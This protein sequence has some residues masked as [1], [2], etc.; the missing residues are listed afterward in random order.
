MKVANT[1][2]C[3]FISIFKEGDLKGCRLY[4]RLDYNRLEMLSI[5]PGQTL[6]TFMYLYPPLKAD[7][8][9]FLTNLAPLGISCKVI[10]QHIPMLV[11]RVAAFG[12][13]FDH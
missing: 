7:V 4:I 1:F 9:V 13:P 2:I 12:K 8:A 3:V 6:G 11:F 10:K 5:A